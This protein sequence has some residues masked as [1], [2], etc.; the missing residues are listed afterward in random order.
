MTSG[1]S[2]WWLSTA[3]LPSFQSISWSVLGESSWGT[4]L[5][6]PLLRNYNGL[7]IA[8][9]IESKLFRP[10]FSPAIAAALPSVPFQAPYI[11]AKLTTCVILLPLRLEAD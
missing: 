4:A 5:V 10:T 11:A 3:V 7:L 6:I 2:F 8:Y 9:G 1:S